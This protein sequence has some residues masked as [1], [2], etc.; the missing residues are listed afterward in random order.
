MTI[1]H[2]GPMML[3]VRIT[4]ALSG[5]CGHP[6][7]GPVDPALEPPL[8]QPPPAAVAVAGRQ[9]WFSADAGM[10]GPNPVIVF[11]VQDTTVAGEVLVWYA[12]TEGGRPA[13]ARNAD[14]Y[15][16]HER[17]SSVF[18]S[19]PSRLCRVPLGSK[20]PD[21]AA[22][23][24]QVDSLLAHRPAILTPLKDSSEGNQKWRQ[25]VMMSCTDQEGWWVAEAQGHLRTT[26]RL[27]EIGH[28]CPA[29]DSVAAAYNAA[30]Y[31]LFRSLLHQVE[32]A[33]S[34]T[35]GHQ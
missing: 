26:H 17:Q 12:D 33:V 10:V 13:R 24:R 1:S 34:H 20:P 18:G 19:L 3:C 6:S 8:L 25:R 23:L 21:W 7:Q 35:S 30:G 9:L 22:A 31:R 15:G 4:I 5:A 27:I 2:A 14:L 28:G 29:T 16:C 11:R 32:S